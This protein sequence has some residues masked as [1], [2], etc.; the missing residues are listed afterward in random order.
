MTIFIFNSISIYTNSVKTK[1]NEKEIQ[2]G[3]I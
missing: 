2:L 3:Q 1:I